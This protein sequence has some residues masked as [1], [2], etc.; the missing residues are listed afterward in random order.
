[1]RFWL[2]QVFVDYFKQKWFLFLFVTVF[3]GAGIFFGALAA[4]TI[5]IDQA[6]HLAG[7][8]N[9]FL[10]KVATAP[11]GQQVYFRYN[12]LNNLYIM[13]ALYL[14]GLTAIGIPFVLVAV[15]SRGFILG[16]TVGFLVRVKAFKG[17]IFA[18]ITVLPHNLLVIPA[19]VMGGVTALSFSTLLIRRRFRSPKTSLKSQ[20]GVYTAVMLVLCLAAGAAGMIETYITPVF[21]KTAAAYI[22]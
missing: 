6:D 15:F 7:Y 17:F 1:M 4:K 19:V 16:F 12:V 21:I 10:E 5:G 3:L 11:P 22:R 14:L 2:K 9:G 18:V 8:L 13:L 20:L